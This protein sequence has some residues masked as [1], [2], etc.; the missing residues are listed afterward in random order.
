MILGM[1]IAVAIAQCAVPPSEIKQILALSY[2]RFDM[3]S[4]KFGW[5]QLIGEGCTDAAVALIEHY[6]QVRSADLTLAQQSELSFHA[7]QALAFAGRGDAAITFLEHAQEYGGTDEWLTY[8]AGNLAFLRKDK[9]ALLRARDRY[10]RIAPGSDRLQFLT[11]FLACPDAPY[12]AAA[13]CK[14]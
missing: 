14:P 11:G 9:A 13:Y 6:H 8:V 5:R 10:A 4:G 12:M 1:T 7:A 2:E 3:S